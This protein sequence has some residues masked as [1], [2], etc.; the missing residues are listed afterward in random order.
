MA[1]K[2]LVF[3][4]YF[5]LKSEQ[6]SENWTKELPDPCSPSLFQTFKQRTRV[7]KWKAPDSCV[8]SL[9]SKRKKG[10]EWKKSCSRPFFPPFLISNAEQTARVENWEKDGPDLVTFFVFKSKKENK[11]R[12]MGNRVASDPCF[13]CFGRPKKQAHE[14]KGR[15]QNGARAYYI[16]DFGGCNPQST[17]LG[18]VCAI[19]GIEVCAALGLYLKCFKTR[20]L[21]LVGL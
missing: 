19:Y 10:E 13:I 7:A 20:H 16:L 17:E 5:N 15:G 2:T 6:G 4:L 14:N 3:F 11:G 21:F 12:N 9:I 8:L 18:Y 1:P